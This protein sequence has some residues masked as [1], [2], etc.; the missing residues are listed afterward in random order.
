MAG[1]VLTLEMIQ[2]AVRQVEAL[3]P[4]PPDIVVTLYAQ[5]SCELLGTIYLTV[6]DARELNKMCP[7]VLTKANW[8]SGHYR[9]ATPLDG[10]F[11][12]EPRWPPFEENR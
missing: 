8:T 11:P 4:P 6:D 12:L 1:D 3:G 9:V 10:A 5:F 2:E 7:L